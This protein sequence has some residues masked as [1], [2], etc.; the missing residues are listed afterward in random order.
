MRNHLPFIVAIGVCSILALLLHLPWKH[1][2]DRDR[3]LSR[4]LVSEDKNQLH[5]LRRLVALNGDTAMPRPAACMG[6]DHPFSVITELA[7]DRVVI[8]ATISD[9]PDGGQTR[10]WF[11]GS[12]AFPYEDTQY[13]SVTLLEFDRSGRLLRWSP[14]Q[15]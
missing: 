14:F 9:K 1:Q 11:G 8:Q 5:V 7:P 12:S 13:W 15:P 3:L 2:D 6:I 4:V 10:P